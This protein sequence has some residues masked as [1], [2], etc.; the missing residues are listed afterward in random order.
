MYGYGWLNQRLAKS[1]GSRLPG[2][3]LMMF[4]DVSAFEPLQQN[5]PRPARLI[6][7]S[8][9]PFRFRGQFAWRCVV[10]FR[11]YAFAMSKKTSSLNQR[12]SEWTAVKSSF[13]LQNHTTYIDIQVSIM[14]RP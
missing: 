12:Q 6:K 14:I 10:K 11:D 7:F 2:A 3:A 4:H 1:K 9:Y 13:L 5:K 8:A